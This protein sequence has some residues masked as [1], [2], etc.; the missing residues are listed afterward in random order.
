MS[1]LSD[2][3]T[4]NEVKAHILQICSGSNFVGHS[5][6]HDL[7]ALGIAVPYVD[8]AYFEDIE[9]RR[10]ETPSLKSLAEKYLNVRI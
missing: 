4:V 8:T 7:K 3:P 6:R 9:E 5:V 2:A 1:W 10:K